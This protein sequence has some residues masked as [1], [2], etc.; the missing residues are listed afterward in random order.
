[1]HLPEFIETFGD[2]IN[3]RLVDLYPPVYD[4]ATR[5]ACG[6]DLGRLGRRPLGAQADAIRAAALSI[7]RN[8]GTNLV[9][10][11]GVGKSMCAAA[12]A[13]LSGRRR[14]LILC[15]P[16]L[17]R[18]WAREVRQTV[19]GARPTI[20]THIADLELLRA[21]AR[22]AAP[23]VPVP[24]FV[25]LSRERA[26]LGAPWRPAYV[27]R[28]V[29]DRDQYGRRIDLPSCGTCYA[30]ILDK[31]GIA[32]APAALSGRKHRCAAC[33]QPLWQFGTATEGRAMVRHRYPLAEYICERLPGFFDLLLV[34]ELHE[35]KARGPAQGIAMGQLA[36]AIGTVL[37]CTGTLMGGYASTLFA[38]L[39]RVNRRFREEFGY[40]DE[41][42]FVARYGIIE[43]QFR[44]EGGGDHVE[45]GRRSKRRLY[46]ARVKEKPGISPAVLFQ[47]I[48]N[49]IFLRLR[50]VAH[51]LPPYHEHIIAVPL[52]REAGTAA[53]GDEREGDGPGTSQHDAYHRLATTLKAEVLR[54][55]ASGG[56]S[57]LLGAYLQ[58]LLS[59]P[60]GCTRGEVVLDKASGRVIAEAPALPEGRVYPKERALLELAIRE[61][62]R[63]RRVL[64]YAVHTETR[65]IT[66]RLR[67]VLEG[68]GLRVAVLKAGTVKP[69]AREEWVARQV[70]D[71][72]DVLIAPPRCVQT[73]LDLVDFPT[74]FWAEIEY[75]VYTLR[76][77]SRRSWRIGQARPVEVYFAV[78]EG[79]L[80]GEA[81]S[82]V[83]KKL[84]A[85][86]LVE[87][88]LPQD[89]LATQDLDE[90]DLM[91]TLAKRLAAGER[92]DSQALESL[93]A[94][95]LALEARSGEALD[96]SSSDAWRVSAAP[97]SLSGASLAAAAVHL[98]PG[99]QLT[100]VPPLED[101]GDPPVAALP[102]LRPPPGAVMMAGQGAL[103]PDPAVT[104]GT[105]PD[106]TP[107]PSRSQGFAPIDGR[108][109][110]RDG[111]H[112]LAAPSVPSRRRKTHA[113]DQ[114]KLFG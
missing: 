68:E 6:I 100:L 98:V 93:F 58:A 9:G 86:M 23:F 83:G 15:P 18:K 21:N 66:P 46:L 113:K 40:G 106:L 99:Q 67:A 110:H 63:G 84:R 62:D 74:I 64:V 2:S 26:K 41:D 78:Y 20:V 101:R 54:T 3:E 4:A 97:T 10:E 87:G 61:R 57:R 95:S 103:V 43:R 29:R 27:T 102:A 108:V 44:K 22:A 114:L 42:K 50:D 28:A 105:G 91:L 89:G 90:G 37:T 70:A 53:T 107:R 35:F 94:E 60:D 30:P 11:M 45:D 24:Q 104:T 77:A 73:G 59:Y 79:T 55:L 17:V 39:W 8:P 13:F 36:E 51:D 19:P 69:E 65:D 96:G 85:A 56:K 47:V 38:L 52:D 7:R 33:D 81:L 112:G 16:H 25:I 111:P 12:A 76:Q 5:A 48:D 34:D 71:G 32:V 72:V 49:S 92:D 88:E 82:L 31:E 109:P 1:M 80:Q 75:S 14:I